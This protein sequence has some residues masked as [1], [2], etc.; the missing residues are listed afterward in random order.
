MSLWVKLEAGKKKA[1]SSHL[2]ILTTDMETL[3]WKQSPAAKGHTDDSGSD[4]I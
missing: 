3:G 1:F 4:S 2:E